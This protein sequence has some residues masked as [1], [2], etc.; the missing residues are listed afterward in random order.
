[1]CSI[2]VPVFAIALLVSVIP[3]T[4][5]T[6]AAQADALTRRLTV[7]EA[8]RLALENNLGIQVAR[9]S[10]AVQDLSL[11][12][13]RA[14]WAPSF[15]TSFQDSSTNSPATSFLSGGQ[16]KTSD[17]RLTSSVAIEQLLKRGGSYSIGWDNTRSTTTNV[18][19]NFSP[20]TRSA[21]SLHF[22]QPLARNFGIDSIRQQLM[23]NQKNREISDV[24]LE[25]TLATTTRTV[26][27][28]YWELAFALASLQV[29]QQSLELA[30]ESLR[31]TQARI[32]IG[33]TP[34]IDLVEAEAEM[35]TRQEAVILSEAQIDE[36]EDT[37]R[38]LIYNPSTPDF[39]SLR[40]EP[41]DLPAFEPA[42]V[43]V[44]TVVRSALGQRTDLQQAR[45][46]LEANDVTIR[47]MRNQ[48][49]PDVT[50][51]V[52]YG[53]SGTGGTQFLRGTGFPGPII[54]E[55]TRGF[56]PVLGDIF[57]NA[58]PAWTVSLNVNYPLGHS[59]QEANLAR[60]R[61]QYSQSQAQIRNQE[62]QVVSQVR[63]VARQVAT[64][65][66][67]VQTTRVSRELAE[68]RL[69]AEQRKFAAGTST[70]FIV[71]QVQRDLAQA[72]NNELRAVLDFNRS[73]VDLDTVQHA[74]IAGGQ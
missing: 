50:A 37:L 18:F 8:V 33:T 46:T 7:E 31:N 39:W 41:T 17:A 22:Q 67:R 30:Q 54:G 35:A 13:T 48:I 58:F 25:Q 56:A 43:N 53:L 24:E 69:D 47:Y 4:G 9:I 28:A 29:Q 26:R 3:A 5:Q 34:P 68:R 6:P 20:Q 62:L 21:L 49:L 15:T 11:A 57:T 42:R 38:A 16:E 72:R 23:I 14:S 44:D 61:L 60:A 52:D 71:F 55:T 64:N 19:S 1:M 59:T 36:A 27:N 2:R 40:I 65:E 10:P 63:S 32:N 45:K 73:L 51:S 70:S 66:Q 12:V 74:P